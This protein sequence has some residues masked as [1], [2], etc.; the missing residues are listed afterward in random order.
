MYICL[1][2]GVLYTSVLLVAIILLGLRSPETFAIQ[3]PVGRFF[4]AVIHYVYTS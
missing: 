1:D 3:D 2:S 4:L